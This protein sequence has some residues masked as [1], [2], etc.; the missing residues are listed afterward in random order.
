MIVAVSHKGVEKGVKSSVA[1]TGSVTSPVGGSSMTGAA[2]GAPLVRKW[3]QAP[4]GPLANAV[5]E[6]IPEGAR[7]IQLKKEALALKAAS[8]SVSDGAS[9][10]AGKDGGKDR[11]SGSGK[12]FAKKPFESGSK[13]G[14]K[15]G[16]K[17]GYK[18]GS[19]SS[20][21]YVRG[22]ASGDTGKGS[23]GMGVSRFGSPRV[24]GVSRVRGDSFGGRFTKLYV[25]SGTSKVKHVGTLMVSSIGNNVFLTF[26]VV[27]DDLVHQYGSSLRRYETMKG[28]KMTDHMLT[29]MMYKFRRELRVKM[30]FL[31]IKNL[32]LNVVFKGS[33][34]VRPPVL[35]AFMVSRVKLLSYSDASG[36]AHNGVRPKASRRV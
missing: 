32:L 13:S 30:P 22:G 8:K 18:P 26:S 5:P 12:E 33:L 35:K 36:I 29:S 27:H 21:S 7:R 10:V 25:N 28:Q 16:S 2:G 14:W 1:V 34:W 31:V 3:G 24:G 20:S 17:P 4:I 6:G 11:V 23:S 9:K 15:S 19:S